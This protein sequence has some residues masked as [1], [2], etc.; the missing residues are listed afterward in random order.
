[1]TVP[2]AAVVPSGVGWV[3]YSTPTPTF[4]FRALSAQP[5]L[6]LAVGGTVS[7]IQLTQLGSRSVPA[8]VINYEVAYEVNGE[9]RTGIVTDSWPAGAS[10]RQVGAVVQTIQLAGGSLNQTTQRQDIRTVSIPSMAPPGNAALRQWFLDKRPEYLDAKFD[11]LTITAAAR[12][13]TL[14]YELVEGSLQ[15]WMRKQL[16]TYNIIGNPIWTDN[17]HNNYSYTDREDTIKLTIAYTVLDVI[18]DPIRAVTDE[19]IVVKITATDC[20][21]GRYTRMTTDATSGESIPEGLA[22]ALYN[23][24]N[25]PHYQGTVKVI[26]EDV[27]GSE[28]IGSRVKITGGDAAWAT[29]SACVQSV[30][31]YLDTGTSIL[32]VGPPAHLTP[33]DILD[34][35]RANRQRRPAISSPSRSSGQTSGGTV[36]LS[37]AQPKSVHGSSPGRWGVTLSVITDVRFDSTTNCLQVKRRDAVVNYLG[38]AGD[39]QNME[40]GQA[41]D[42]DE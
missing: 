40:G 6:N 4:N 11:K 15:D 20:P 17:P 42:C 26:A 3:D 12:A 29:M 34:L 28:P 18:G 24:L 38:S 33:S 14:P 39:W 8:V 19:I 22:Q 10:S 41:E 31:D 13:E 7:E 23:D 25:A 35:R 21:T 2:L 27:S 9:Q 16:P 36:D 5:E 37:S 30:T 1:M 32:Q